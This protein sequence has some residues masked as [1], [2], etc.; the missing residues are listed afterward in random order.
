M[1]GEGGRG[2]EGGGGGEGEERTVRQQH[3][4]HHQPAPPLPP[5]PPPTPHPLSLSASSPA[6]LA[7]PSRI[8]TLS[9]G[10]RVGGRRRGGGDQREGHEVRASAHG[11]LCLS[12]ALCQYRAAR[13]RRVRG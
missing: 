9:T 3:P 10:Q 2:A 5:A 4:R 8:P 6:P 7:A 11:V 1:K 12:C 13:S